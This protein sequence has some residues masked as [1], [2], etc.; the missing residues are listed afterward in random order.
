MKRLIAFRPRGKAERGQALIL[1]VF[2]IIGLFGVSA[3]AI[4]GGNAYRERRKTQNA[5][6]AAALSGAIARIEGRDWREAA[7]ASAESNGFD[8]NGITNTV[9][10]N[11]PP[12]EGPYATD[13]Q[14]IQVIITSHLDT[15]FGP[16]IGIPQTTVSTQAISQTKPAEYGPMF[17]GYAVV[18]LAPHSKCATRPGFWLH[19]ESTLA[20][21]GGGLFV[22]SD[23]PDCAYVQ[24]GSGSLRIE[25][26]APFSIVGGA[27]IQKPQLHTPFPPQTGAIPMA[28]PPAFQMPTKGC[29]SKEAKVIGEEDGGDGTSMSSGNWG[30]D[31]PPLGVTNLEGGVYCLSGNVLVESG[32]V[33]HGSSVVLVIEHGFVRFSGG[34]EIQLSAPRQ[35][36]REGLLIYMPME[37]HNKLVLNGNINSNFSGAILAPGA[38]VIIAGNENRQ[39]GYHSQ[40]I[41]YTI[42]VGGQDLI[43]VKYQDEQNYDAF[44]MPE[45]RL[46]Q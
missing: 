45:V 2:S 15:F 14:F 39:Q 33:L 29:G 46:T 3:L 7:L 4:D 24:N 37:N 18:S 32:T 38:E 22:N 41:G 11:T 20:L 34:A 16:V 28:Y 19:Y 44:R 42:E 25:G 21:Q 6:D 1:I 17:E 13:P 27:S 36:D 30:E 8:N 26:D 5:A 43:V 10:L 35:G 40:I 23:N 9:E 31:F 12:I